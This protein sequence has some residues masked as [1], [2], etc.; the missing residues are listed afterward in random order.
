MPT[1]AEINHGENTNCWGGLLPTPREERGVSEQCCPHTA[2]LAAWGS[3]LRTGARTPRTAQTL[4]FSGWDALRAGEGEGSD[5]RCALA[6]PRLRDRAAPVRGRRTKGQRPLPLL[7]GGPSLGRREHIQLPAW[8][9]Q[10]REHGATAPPP[11]AL[12]L[13]AAVARGRQKYPPVT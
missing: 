12:P 5:Y 8:E 7:G 4:K 6:R 9:T 3:S 13:T 2:A 11:A 10:P 1:P